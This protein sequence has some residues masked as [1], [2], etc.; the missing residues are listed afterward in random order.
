MSYTEYLDL[1][2]K[3]QKNENAEYKAVVFDLAD[4]KKMSD[5]ERYDAQLK[6]IKTFNN[7]LRDL[8]AIEKIIGT[9]LLLNEKPV[10]QVNNIA[11][12]NNP[13][14]AYLSNPT[15]LNG[16]SFVFYFKNDIIELDDIKNLFLQNA[17]RTKN[18]YCYHIAEGKFETLD[19]NEQGKKYW[20]GHVAQQLSNLKTDKIQYKKEE[21]EEMTM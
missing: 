2:K 7:M 9:K 21:Q 3:A 19:I 8:W 20:I 14:F 13:Q 12:P 11:K 1:F 5:Q 16:D 6:S 10:K 17:E 18:T 15:I 4:S